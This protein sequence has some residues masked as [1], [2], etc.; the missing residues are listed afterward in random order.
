MGKPKVKTF[1]VNVTGMTEDQFK[2]VN[3]KALK[4]GTTRAVIIKGLITEAIEQ[5]G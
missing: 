3:E 4:F 2:W 5:D 1:K